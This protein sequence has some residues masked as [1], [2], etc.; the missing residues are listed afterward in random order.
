MRRCEPFCDH[1]LSLFLTF[2]LSFCHSLSAFDLSFAF[3]HY[4]TDDVAI[5]AVYLITVGQ[6][7]SVRGSFAISV[8]L[9]QTNR[10]MRHWK[11]YDDHLR[12]ASVY[13]FV[14]WFHFM[15]LSPLHLRVLA[16]TS[17]KKEPFGQN[18]ICRLFS[19]T[20]TFSYSIRQ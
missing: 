11:K 6:A 15:S 9:C 17:S 7:L 3:F 2:S 5:G 13:P 8:N 14:R 20:K 10:L 18:V 1:A 16:N 4:L 19:I 12:L